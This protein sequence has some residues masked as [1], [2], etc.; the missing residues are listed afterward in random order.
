[1]IEKLFRKSIL[2]YQGLIV[3]SSN[4]YILYKEEYFILKSYSLGGKL[5]STYCGRGK[6]CTNVC[7]EFA[8][9]RKVRNATTVKD[10]CLAVLYDDTN[11]MQQ[12]QNICSGDNFC[13]QTP[14]K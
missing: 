14:G 2:K 5:E 12:A 10:E 13:H 6:S 9:S 3:L 8:T 11:P 4:I 7:D 1:M